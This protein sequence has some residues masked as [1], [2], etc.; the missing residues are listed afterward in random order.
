MCPDCRG[1]CPHRSRSLIVFNK[2][3][4]TKNY[5]SVCSVRTVSECTG[6]FRHYYIYLLIEIALYLYLFNCPDH[7]MLSGRT[8]KGMKPIAKS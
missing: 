8:Q 4:R 6:C 2:L 1:A 3:V 7:C 5:M